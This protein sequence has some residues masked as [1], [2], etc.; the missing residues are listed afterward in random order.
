MIHVLFYTNSLKSCET[1]VVH[2]VNGQKY[3]SHHDWGV[4][5]YPESR[6]ITLLF[7]L[8][9]MPSPN[10]GGETVLEPILPISIL[11]YASESFIQ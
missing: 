4:S 3:D 11:V 1:Q 6:F 9:Q 8:T 7:Y 10:A 5:G 2:Y